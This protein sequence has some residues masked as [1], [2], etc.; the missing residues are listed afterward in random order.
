MAEDQGYNGDVWN[1]Q[2]CVLLNKLGWGKIGDYNMDIEGEDGKDCG[3]DSFFKY[4][5][6]RK[7]ICEQG[8]ILESKCYKTTSF[9]NSDLQNWIT[10][11][12]T[13]INKLKHSRPFYEKFPELEET[14]FN[15]GIIFIWFSDHN[16][17]L[18]NNNFFST[19]LTS[20]NIPKSRTNAAFNRIY[21]LENNLILKL[22]SVWDTIDKFY[23]NKKVSLEYYYPASERS[24]NPIHRNKLLTIDYMFSK[25]ILAEGKT[26]SGGVNRVVFYFGNLEKESFQTLYSGLNNIGFIDYDIPLFIFVYQR[27]EQFRKIQPD[28]IDLFSKGISNNRLVVEIDDMEVFGDLPTFLRKVQ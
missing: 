28:V 18:Q 11:I 3:I 25:F 23:Q 17:Y 8:V 26:E 16:K 1:R 15:N 13:K 27:S 14:S 7:S 5:D 6:I 20:V 24:L 9:T 12:N 2:V 10:R 4:M 21:V 22:C 19:A